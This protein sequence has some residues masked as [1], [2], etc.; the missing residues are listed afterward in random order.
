MDITKYFKK[1]LRGT[2]LLANSHF[3]YGSTWK[4]V[5]TSLPLDKSYQGDFSSAEYTINIELGKD[6]KEIIKCLLTA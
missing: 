6:K 5:E 3:S 1:G 4:A 2:I